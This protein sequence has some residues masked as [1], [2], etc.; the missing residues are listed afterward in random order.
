M[1][2]FNLR[3]VVVEMEWARKVL[4]SFAEKYGDKGIAS[5]DLEFAKD[6]F[7]DGALAA[8]NMTPNV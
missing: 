6:C 4:D 5:V 7:I 8:R 1:D 3:G 2:T